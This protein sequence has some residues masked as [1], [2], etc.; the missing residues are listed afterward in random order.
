VNTWELDKEYFEWLCCLIE[1]PDTNSRKVL[2]ILFQKEFVW[3]VLND[4][5][6]AQDGKDL[7]REFLDERGYSATTDFIE[8][9]CSMLELLIG[10]S[11]KLAFEGD[12]EPSVW[13]WGLIKNISLHKFTD[14][15]PFSEDRVDEILD[16]VIWRT[17]SPLGHGGLFPLARSDQDQR[18]VELWYQ[19]SAYLLERID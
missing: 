12:G 11:R 16:R 15:K 18:R 17:Y 4:D 13:F 10:L 19:M 1:K 9:G 5:N 8:I 14:D 6:R 2:E 7:R 3:M